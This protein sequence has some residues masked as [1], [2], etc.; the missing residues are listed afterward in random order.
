[1]PSDARQGIEALFGRVAEPTCGRSQ[2]AER[3]VTPTPERVNTMGH[4][5]QV[6]WLA[7]A[8]A[9]CRL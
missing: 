4:S 1:M 6:T 3:L 8:A 7:D 5:V 9:S 2:G